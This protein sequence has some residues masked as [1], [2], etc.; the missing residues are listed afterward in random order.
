MDDIN[1]AA[2]VALLDFSYN[3]TLGKLDEAYRAVKAIDSPGI[4]ENM[5]QMC[6]KTRRLDVAEVCLGNMGHVRGAA[7]VREAVKNSKENGTN[8]DV[9]VGVLAIQLGLLDDA[10]RIFREVRIISH[11]FFHL[12]LF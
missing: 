10:A 2:K 12:I 8:I 9:A 5:A 1:D 6:V 11:I 4:W 3:L 7:A